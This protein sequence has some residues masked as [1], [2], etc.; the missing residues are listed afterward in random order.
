[1][2]AKVDNAAIQDGFNLY[3]HFILF[4][5][6]GHWTIIQQGLNKTNKMARRYHWIYIT[7]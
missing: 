2:S 4:D 3:H 6:N 5:D 7:C 1:M